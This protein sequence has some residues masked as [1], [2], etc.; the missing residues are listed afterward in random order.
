MSS[1]GTADDAP[2]TGRAK[3]ERLP[4]SKY[5]IVK[6]AAAA[7]GNYKAQR[8]L[9]QLLERREMRMRRREQASRDPFVGS[10]G[11]AELCGL[12]VLPIDP[13]PAHLIIH[14]QFCK[15]RENRQAWPKT[16]TVHAGSEGVWCAL[17]T[18]AT[19]N[20][21]AAWLKWEKFMGQPLPW[22][23][24]N[25]P[26]AKA[27]VIGLVCLKEPMKD[28]AQDFSPWRDANYGAAAFRIDK[29]LAFDAPVYGYESPQGFTT[30][31]AVLKNK[32]HLVTQLKNRL[33]GGDYKWRWTCLDEDGLANV[34]M[35]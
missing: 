17:M 32:A 10:W 26:L 33:R 30:R 34:I 4:P 2:A 7:L 25:A 28:A 35:R 1:T 24:D 31:V 3:L 16:W 14:P 18:K 21:K 9:K 29:C 19:S 6:K 20:T 22:P 23:L 8:A 13:I 15:D 5:K 27:A 12:I 11:D